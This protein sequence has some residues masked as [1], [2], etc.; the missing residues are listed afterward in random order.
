[1]K[2]PSK[3]EHL[4]PMLLALP[5]CLY[6]TSMLV[7][8]SF[9]NRLL[10]GVYAS[11]FAITAALAFFSLRSIYLELTP[12]FLIV[13][14]FW[15]KKEIPWAEVRR[16]GWLGSMSGTFSISVGHRIE[17][18]DWICFTPGDRTKQTD[19]IAELR[20]FALHATF[21]VD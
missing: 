15:K 5:S 20:K 19:L 18:Y 8:L 10:T 16:V 1:M 3:I 2:F 9:R 12:K 21:E 7:Q 4:G 11:L 14:R 6:S 13:G 17:D